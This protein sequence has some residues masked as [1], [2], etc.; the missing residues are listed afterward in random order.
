M[1]GIKLYMDREQKKKTECWNREVS[2]IEDNR[3]KEAARFHSGG[4]LLLK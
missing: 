1:Q 3:E 4:I 2:N